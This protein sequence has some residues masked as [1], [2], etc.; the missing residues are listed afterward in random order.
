MHTSMT[1]K[2]ERSR[3]IKRTV[4]AACEQP[5]ICLSLVFYWVW[6]IS[7]FQSPASLLDMRV[8]GNL[9][10]ASVSLLAASAVA[11]AVAMVFHAGFSRVAKR[12]WYLPCVCL[13]M[14]VGS[15]VF[16]VI[17][18]IQPGIRAA[19]EVFAGCAMG[20]GAAL[21]V[22]ELG[23]VFAQLGSF[24]ALT[25]GIL[26]VVGGAALFALA[27]FA[28]SEV[29]SMAVSAAPVVSGIFLRKQAKLFPKSKYYGHGLET[30]LRFPKKF[31]LTCLVQGVAL[32]AMTSILASVSSSGVNIAALQF[33]AFIAGA[34]LLVGTT[35][36][37]NLDFN[38]LVYQ[39]GLPLMAGGFV[40]FA[41]GPQ[42]VFASGFLLVVGHCYMYILIT[43]INS[44]F[45][46]NL[47]CPPGWIASLSTLFMVMGQIFGVA[48]S[49][50]LLFTLGEG[51]SGQSLALSPNPADLAS[52]S[53]LLTFLLP[54]AALWLLN[55]DNLSSG[56][57][58]FKPD[59]QRAGSVEQAVLK[60][61]ATDFRLTSREM[62]ICGLLAHG[63]NREYISQEL[64]L[65]KETIKSHMA[66]I[67]RKLMVHSQQELIDLFEQE[68]R[69]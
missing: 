41:C 51:V 8:E 7:F 36:L 54:L 28:P 46:H 33:T 61:I 15:A 60:Q 59:S 24:Y 14:V 21:F 5:F 55:G 16:A 10:L 9:Q 62:E 49:G 38:H 30:P 47:N 68:K 25:S 4:Q 42:Y 40:L 31:A 6:Q 67:Y 19:L 52:L 17:G 11:Y 3:F 37:L 43:C 44:H 66:N 53:V 29:S 39:I 63:R 35:L 22:V 69:P 58:A 50:G 20:T 27:S 48:I 12:A 13:C 2:T 64:N 57:G 1:K 18:F 45:S 23:R 56:W 65:S 26:S 32:G 34:V